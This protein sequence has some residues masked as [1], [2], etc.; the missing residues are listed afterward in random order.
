MKLEHSLVVRRSPEDT[1]AFSTTKT[2]YLSN[3]GNLSAA[4]NT[5]G[6]LVFMPQYGLLNFR[7]PDARPVSRGNRE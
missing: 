3:G 6:N 1:F 2:V 7:F 5:M 4:D